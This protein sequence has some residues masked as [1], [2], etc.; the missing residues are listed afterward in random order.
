MKTSP[1]LK[2]VG[3]KQNYVTKLLELLPDDYFKSYCEPFLG[4]AHG[5]PKAVRLLVT[6]AIEQDTNQR[7]TNKKFICH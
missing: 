7:A 2:W 5:R 3:G 4:A 1:I 6:P